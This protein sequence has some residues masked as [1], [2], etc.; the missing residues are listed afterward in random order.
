MKRVSQR[1]IRLRSPRFSLNYQQYSLHS[2][3]QS[4]FKTYLTYLASFLSCLVLFCPILY[5]GGYYSNQQSPSLPPALVY[6]DLCSHVNATLMMAI[7]VYTVYIHGLYKQVWESRQHPIDYTATIQCL[8]KHYTDLCS[9]YLDYTMYIHITILL[10]IVNRA[11][12][13][14]SAPYNGHTN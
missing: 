11:R 8:Y 12:Q 5:L 4:S 2:P 3:H 14:R 7:Q 9:L 6:S 10:R 1:L 13:V